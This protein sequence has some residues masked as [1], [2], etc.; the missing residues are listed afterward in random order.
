LN[1]FASLRAG[2]RFVVSVPLIHRVSPNGLYRACHPIP[3]L[4]LVANDA[5]PRLVLS[6]AKDGLQFVDN[7]TKLA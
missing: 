2:L 7:S 6:G 5:E 1:P 3:P 4:A